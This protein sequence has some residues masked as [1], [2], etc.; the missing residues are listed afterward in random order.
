MRCDARSRSSGE[1]SLATT[2]AAG[3]RCA[4]VVSGSECGKVYVWDLQSRKL[5]DSLVGHNDMV[6]AVDTHM[7]MPI[8]ASGS[9][10]KDPTVRLWRRKEEE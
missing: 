5:D 6:L 7:S 9:C 8:L 1:L 3:Q 2:V 10:G 4:S